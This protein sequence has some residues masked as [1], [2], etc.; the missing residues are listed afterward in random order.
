MLHTES[1]R[2][3]TH[4]RSQVEAGGPDSGDDQVGADVVGVAG[5]DGGGVRGREARDDDGGEAQAGHARPDHD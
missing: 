2:G 5:G 1:G 4:K 3:R